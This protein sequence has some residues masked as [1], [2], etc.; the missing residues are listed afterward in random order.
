[1]VVYGEVVVPGACHLALALSGAELLWKTSSCQIADVIFPQAL[2]LAPDAERLVQ[3]MV[4]PAS[5]Q[6]SFEIASSVSKN[7]A[8][9]VVVH[10]TGRMQQETGVP[11]QVDLAALRSRCSTERMPSELYAQLAAAQIV[12]GTSFRWVQALWTDAQGE[13]LAQLQRP[14]AVPDVQGYPL[15]PS[16]LDTCFQLVAAG[17]IDGVQLPFALE[18]LIFYGAG[19]ADET[20]WCHVVRGDT[21][22]DSSR[23]ANWNITLC[24]ADGQVVAALRGFQTRA[25]S[26]SAIQHNRLRT[27]WLYTL[28]WDPQPLAAVQGSET[29]RALSGWLLVGLEA[30]IEARLAAGLAASTRGERAAP[31]YSISA[32]AERAEIASVLQQLAGQAAEVGVLFWGALPDGQSAG[33]EMAQERCAALLL[34]SQSL[35]GVPAHLWVVT[36]GV[37]SCS[38]PVNAAV[39]GS[40]WGFA[41]TLLGL[42][43]A[44]QIVQEGARHLLLVSRRGIVA[45]SQ[46]LLLAELAE[47]GAEVQVVQADIAEEESLRALLA[48]CSEDLPLAGIFHC[49]GVLDDGMVTMQ[50]AERLR[51][52]LRPKVVGGWHLH[53]LTATRQLDYFV[54]FSSAASLLGS[55]GQSSYAAANGFLDGLMQARRSQGLVGLSIQWGPWSEVGMAAAVKGQRWDMGRISPDQGRLLLSH[56]SNWRHSPAQVGV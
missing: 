19:G 23:G 42:Q 8:E 36:R 51:A 25:A 4:E 5:R 20:F 15:F 39:G 44:R 56:L 10:A 3:L 13:V 41:R 32:S 26:A 43:V 16:L 21:P 45:E 33:H 22:A 27:D 54:A 53:C 55:P 52:V 11:P 28:Q 1:H 2:V 18:Q 24:R 38:D 37:H 40:L 29:G 48:R 17:K 31:L 34:L 14:Q 7:D 46:R 6:G 12:L 35:A 47:A 9:E 50:T 49:A 30:E